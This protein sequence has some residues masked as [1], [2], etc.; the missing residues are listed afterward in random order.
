MLLTW[1]SRSWGRKQYQ[2]YCMTKKGKA[3]ALVKMHVKCVGMLG[4]FCHS[5]ISL[6][7]W[8][9]LLVNSWTVTAGD[10]LTIA[11]LA[12]WQDEKTDRFLWKGVFFLQIVWDPFQ[13]HIPLLSIILGF[14]PSENVLELPNGILIVSCLIYCMER[15][16]SPVRDA[17]VKELT[18]YSKCLYSKI[19][20]KMFC[21]FNELLK[22]S[23]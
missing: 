19:K 1:K 8:W 7:V 17:C 15:L 5:C 20:R 22:S 9:W 16:F 6:C 14:P 13:H 18:I 2:C 3:C 12:D 23:I 10:V 21:F 4:C 11:I